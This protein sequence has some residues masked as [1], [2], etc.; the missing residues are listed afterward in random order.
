MHV[1]PTDCFCSNLTIEVPACLWAMAT[2]NCYMLTPCDWRHFLCIYYL[3][4][5]FGPFLLLLLFFS[6]WGDWDSFASL[7]TFNIIT[8]S[9]PSRWQERTQ[10]ETARV[11]LFIKRKEKKRK[12]P[13]KTKVW[14][15]ICDARARTHPPTRIDKSSLLG[16]RNLLGSVPCFQL[17]VCWRCCVAYPF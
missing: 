15:W 3:Y 2:T 4:L 12:A 8:L 1:S 9:R 11:L 7:L 17:C 14:L 6:F 13:T 16:C 5:G 10:A